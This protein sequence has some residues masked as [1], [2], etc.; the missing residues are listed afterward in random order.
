MKLRTNQHHPH[1][2]RG[3]LESARL[4]FVSTVCALVLSTTASLAGPRQVSECYSVIDGDILVLADSNVAATYSTENEY[5]PGGVVYFEFDDNVS[6]TRCTAMREAMDEWMAVAGVVFVPR[7]DESNFVHI[8][9]SDVNASYVGVEGG[10]QDVYIVSWDSRFIMAH[11]L[12]HALGFWHEQSRTDRNDF[13]RIN[14]ENIQT[15][16]GHNFDLEDESGT[17]G[18]YDFDSLMHYGECDFSTNPW[19]PLGGGQTI[20]VLP[21]NEEWQGRIGQR[22]HF[23][24]RDIEGMRFIYGQ[25]DVVF[26]DHAYSGGDSEGTLTRPFTDFP[27][28]AAQAPGGSTA[29]IRGGV[30]SSVGLY[31]RAIRVQPYLGKVILGD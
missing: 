31:D 7:Y 1:R 14:T 23:S 19:C 16:V 3:R 11:E 21:P 13:I 2:T 29:W 28:A 22:D 8:Y 20:T 25:G 5:W 27:D 15:G 26:V 17:V 30:Y 18:P 9:H 4:G 12:C 24:D 10:R 6:D